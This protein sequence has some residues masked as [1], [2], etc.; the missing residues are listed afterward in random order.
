[1]HGAIKK[2]GVNDVNKLSGIFLFVKKVY[3]YAKIILRKSIL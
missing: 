1:M 2:V 3:L